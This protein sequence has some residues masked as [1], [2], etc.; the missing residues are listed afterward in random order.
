[1]RD[2]NGKGITGARA[3]APIWAEFML[4]ATSGEPPRQFSIPSDIQFQE[5]DPQTGEP[6]RTWT[7]NPARVALREGQEIQP[8]IKEENIE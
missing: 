1:M 4:K 5:V 6:A 8:D 2:T 7:S 3:A